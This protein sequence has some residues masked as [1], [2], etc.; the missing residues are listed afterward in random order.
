MLKSFIEN[1]N[2]EEKGS[3]EDEGESKDFEMIWAKEANQITEL[4]SNNEM[5]KNEPAFVIEKEE[6][7]NERSWSGGWYVL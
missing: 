1:E 6:R 2:R 3:D 5:T 7:Q 4:E